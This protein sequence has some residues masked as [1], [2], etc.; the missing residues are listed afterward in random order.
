MRFFCAYGLLLGAHLT[1][2]ALSVPHPSPRP[3]E[4]S[5]MRMRLPLP[6]VVWLLALV[7]GPR[8]GL[9]PGNIFAM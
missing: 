8:V 9:V 6:M 3:L 7:F 5:S 1:L 2:P 4:A